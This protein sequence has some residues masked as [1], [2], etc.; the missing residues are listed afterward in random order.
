[1]D[2]HR[3]ARRHG[4]SDADIRH[5][6]HHQLAQYEISDDD[7]PTRLLVI[8]ADRA[9]NLLEIVAIERDDRSHIAI[10]AMPLRPGYRNLL[11]APPERDTS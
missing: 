11:P 4:V 2:V 7:G 1:M 10:H 9:A 5:A 3:S 8:G 6:F